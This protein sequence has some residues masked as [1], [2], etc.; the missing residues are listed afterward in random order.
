MIG[1]NAQ[2]ASTCIV[3]KDVPDNYYLDTAIV[4]NRA[5]LEIYR[6]ERRV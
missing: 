2:I 1:A 5:L 4:L 3:Y 6:E